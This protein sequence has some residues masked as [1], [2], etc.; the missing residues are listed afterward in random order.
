MTLTRSDS[1]LSARD[2]EILKD[3]ILTYILSAEPVSSRSVARQGRSGLSAAT[4]RNVMADL[5]ESG[6][7]AQPHTSAGRVPTRAAYHL[8]IESLMATERVSARNRRYI[9]ETLKGPAT[10]AESRMAVA[11]HLL[12]ELSN[13]VGLVV[14]PRLGDTV[15]KAIDFVPLDGRK[16][17][18]VVVST[19]GFIDNKVIELGEEVSREDLQRSSN[20]LTE[21]F[22]GWSLRQIRDHLL[23]LMS[24]ERAQMDRLLALAMDLARSG[25]DVDDGPEVLVDGTSALLAQPELTD[26][27]RVRR[28]FETF[29]DKARL[30]KLLGLC[31]QGQ[32]VRVVI[33]DD[34]AVTS[35]L[36]FSLVATTYGV[37]NRTLGT[38]GIF[39]PSRMEYQKVIPLVHYLGE[40]L[41][42]AL[43]E[44]FGEPQGPR[45]D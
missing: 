37:G 35:E 19:D 9:D 38:L 23:R 20:Y 16:V 24:E 41:S 7:L 34:S 28:L 8:F 26:I 5:E 17:L 25:L 6:Y 10:D 4:I 32:G 22:S 21:S 12:S 43:A 45:K 3:V 11:S 40:T 27:Q 29:A 18:C 13:Q 36:D 44:G 33:G 1:Q 39:G 2:R 30:V 15:L 31:I 42:R 14:T